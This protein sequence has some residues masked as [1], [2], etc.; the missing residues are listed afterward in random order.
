MPKEEIKEEKIDEEDLEE[1]LEEEIQNKKEQEISEEEMNLLLEEFLSKQNQRFLNFT[2][3]NTQKISSSNLSQLVGLE[4]IVPEESE[5]KVFQEESKLEYIKY[6]GKENSKYQ[7]YSPEANVRRDS[8]ESKTSNDRI[9][10][11]QK[12]F[13]KKAFGGGYGKEENSD[14]YVFV[15][16]TK[17]FN[18]TYDVK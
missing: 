4:S 6:E 18:K 14:K 3:Q 15:E 2:R 12:N 13:T 11:E 10:E 9:M 1:I 8:P 7:S 17:K 16:D 5:K